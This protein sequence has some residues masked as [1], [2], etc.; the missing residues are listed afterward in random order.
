[1]PSG[2]RWSCAATSPRVTPGVWPPGP[3]SWGATS[4]SMWRPCGRCAGVRSCT[5]SA[6]WP[7]PT[8]SRCGA[9]HQAEAGRR[10]LCEH[11]LYGVELLREV[12]GLPPETLEVVRSHHERWDGSGYP[13]GLGG[14][15]IPLAARVFAL[16]DAFDEAAG[17]P[18][19]GSRSRQEAVAALRSGSGRRFDPHLCARFL[20]LIEDP[21]SRTA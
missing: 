14:E 11:T 5:T 9:T 21:N 20:G 18:S 10:T 13:E 3:R 19:A 2:R 7:C 1:M 15:E 8:A 4:A 17:E 12:P 6:C 16:A